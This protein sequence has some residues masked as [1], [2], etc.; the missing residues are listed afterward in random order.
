MAEHIKVGQIGEDIAYQYLLSK[1]YKVIERNVRYPW[2]EIDIICIKRDKTLVFVEVKALKMF[3][4]SVKHCNECF[5]KCFTPED[6]LN[7]AKLKKIR[8]TA[9]LYANSHPELIDEE[10]GWQIDLIAIDINLYAQQSN[11]ETKHSNLEN[12]NIKELL[13]NSEI[14]H[15]ENI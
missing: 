8:R 1:E 6:N 12:S 11:I 4:S 10:K 13:K 14:R 5:T 7:S 2:G 15:Y 3:N 9:I